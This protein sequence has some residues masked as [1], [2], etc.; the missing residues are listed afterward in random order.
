V[1]IRY[2][3]PFKR[4]I[5]I[6]DHWEIPM[7]GGKCRVIEEEG[8]AKALE[9]TFEKQP[10]HFAPHA[11]SHAT[12]VVKM[13]ITGRD[14]R[15]TFV[16]R[17]LDNAANFLECMFDIDLATDEI[18]AKYEGET[19]DEEAQIDI[20]GGSIGRHHAALPLSYDMLT[21]AIVAA[22]KNDG[23]KFEATL[24]AT[25]RKA[26]AR[27]EFINSF[28]YS[29]LLIES[30]YGE[31]QF[32]K[33]GLQAALKANQEFRGFVDAGVKGV[34]SAK[35]DR[36]SDTAKLLT[37]TPSVDVVIDHL[38]EMRGFYFHGNVKRK[39]AWKPDQQ[40]AAES[41]AL[42]AIGIVMQVSMNAA[43]PIFEPDVN[44]RHFDDAMRA[45]A[46]LVFEIK[47]K[48]REPEETFSREHQINISMPG[49][50]PTPR[51]AFAA[52]QQFLLAF[53]H[54]QPVSALL[55]AECT[56]QGT[57]HKVFELTFHLEE[58]KTENR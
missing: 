24:V 32:K 5:I 45:G 13:T 17:Q 1:R 52:A 43:A 11:Q 12:G 18:E 15:M 41:L 51:T 55:S 4:S 48:F 53:Q 28:R 44:Q 58:D 6:D 22:E 57:G 35:D 49:T 39:D 54:N 37:T 38:V 42:L 23:P 33:A 46:R 7:Q 9:V 19:P 40:G 20:K 3:V 36:T 30:L 47:F 10:L 56:L 8:Y 14:D 31:G 34:I 29:F 25:A 50:K 27:Q 16:T 26:L 2:T 21:R